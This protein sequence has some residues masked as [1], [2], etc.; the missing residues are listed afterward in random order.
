MSG[1]YKSGHILECVKPMEEGY[2]A[3]K[4]NELVEM[5][6]RILR[7]TGKPCSHHAINMHALHV[8]CRLS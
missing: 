1:F 3:S 6:D 2:H 8:H 7:E 4:S 5:I